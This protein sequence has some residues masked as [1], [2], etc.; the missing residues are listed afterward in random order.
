M[1]PLLMLTLGLQQS[2]R[3]KIECWQGLALAACEAVWGCFVTDPT[4]DS[5]MCSVAFSSYGH[6]PHV[7]SVVHNR[8]RESVDPK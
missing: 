1:S 4:H 8:C 3:R 7:C 5:R 2:V 6:L